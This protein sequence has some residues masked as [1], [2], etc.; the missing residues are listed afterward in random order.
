MD[1]TIWVFVEAAG[2]SCCYQVP[3]GQ[4]PSAAYTAKDEAP[5]PDEN[6]ELIPVVLH[7]EPE[8]EPE[9]SDEFDVEG[10]ATDERPPEEEES[11]EN[12][13]C[14]PQIY[15]LMELVDEV[16][17]WEYPVYSLVDIVFPTKDAALAYA[18]D[19]PASYETEDNNPV[20]YCLD[21]I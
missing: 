14:P 8:P 12:I 15:A 10:A 3:Y 16:D 13:A 19:H 17:C 18:I 9:E 11:E 20:V 4:S 2:V 21:V 1:D 7:E 5:K 6:Q